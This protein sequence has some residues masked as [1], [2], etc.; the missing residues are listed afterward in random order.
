MSVIIWVAIG[1]LYKTKGPAISQNTLENLS[2][3]CMQS[4]KLATLDAA[5]EYWRHVTAAAW[6]KLSTV[7]KAWICIGT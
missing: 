7:R 1:Q 4:Y 2:G 5:A 6:P 3:F